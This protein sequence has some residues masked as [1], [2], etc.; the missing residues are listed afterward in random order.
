MLSYL[1]TYIN[2]GQGATFK[3]RWLF[4]AFSK[5]VE[6]HAAAAALGYFNFIKIHSTL[7]FTPAMAAGVTDRL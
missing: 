2:R 5:K 3:I 6:S 7:R 1:T 4:S